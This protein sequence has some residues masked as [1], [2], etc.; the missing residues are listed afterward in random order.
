M[1]D[2][3]EKNSTR[4]SAIGIG[5]PKGLLQRIKAF[6]SR[7]FYIIGIVLWGYGIRLA[8]TSGIYFDSIFFIIVGGQAVRIGETIADGVELARWNEYIEKELDEI[9]RIYKGR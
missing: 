9:S 5:A 4:S 7:L 3:G 1:S 6:F 8:V 2:R